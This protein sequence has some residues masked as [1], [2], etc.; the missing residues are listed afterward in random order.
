MTLQELLI[1]QTIVILIGCFLISYF[2]QKG[3]NL[4]TKEDVA[5]ITSK[6]ESVKTDYKQ[7]Y[8]LSKTERE[9]YNEMIKLIEGFL[10]VIKRHETASESGKNSLTREKI[11]G[12]ERL[13][14]SWLSFVDSANIVLSKAFVFLK[15]KNYESFKNAF[16]ANQDFAHIR[17]NL[18]DAMR[19]SIYHGT[20]IKAANDSKNID[21]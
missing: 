20:Q 5:E 9:F 10:A 12:D 15:D 14:E 1:I 8:D 18:L 11:M 6:I 19:E 2:Q 21:Y 7:F 16:E 17:L 4:A 3:K 13:K